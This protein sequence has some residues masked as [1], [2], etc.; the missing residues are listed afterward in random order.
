VVG[1]KLAAVLEGPIPCRTRH[2]G[3]A[4]ESHL[5]RRI[6]GGSGC[7]CIRFLL[8]C[9]AKEVRLNNTWGAAISFQFT[10]RVAGG[11]APV[12]QPAARRGPRSPVRHRRPPL[13]LLRA[14]AAG[15]PPSAPREAANLASPSR[16]TA[17]VI[18]L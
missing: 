6:N 16:H 11:P 3:G 12:A 8:I 9:G 17:A 7:E 15:T 13:P 4:A 14:A 5:A 2:T 10:D 1:R 18:P